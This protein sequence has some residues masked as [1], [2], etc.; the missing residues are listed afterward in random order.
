MSRHRAWKLH[1]RAPSSADSPTTDGKAQRMKMARCR[2]KLQLRQ[3]AVYANRRRIKR[4]KGKAL[5]KLRAE[6]AEKSFAH[7]YETGGMRRT[8]LR[9]ADNILKRLLIH[10]C[11]YNL[12]LLMRKLCGAGTPKG[13]A[14]LLK[15]LLDL[16]SCLRTAR[17]RL[18][19]K[20]LLRD[21]IRCGATSLADPVV[22]PR[23]PDRPLVG[24]L[25]LTSRSV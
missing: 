10:A 9:G 5:R 7:I 3:S 16:F 13:L 19:P 20:K 2:S 24:Q 1:S 25:L 11:G 15:R 4:N 18:N 6:L 8:H 17:S 14:D 12:G 21:L 22:F 23:F